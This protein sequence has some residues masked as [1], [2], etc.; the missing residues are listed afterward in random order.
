MTQPNTLKEKRKKNPRLFSA[1]QPPPGRMLRTSP[2]RASV[3]RSGQAVT[4][5]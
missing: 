5:H 2:D 3:R 4:I 1:A